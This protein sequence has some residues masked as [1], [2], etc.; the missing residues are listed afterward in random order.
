[1]YMG[2]NV[3]WGS[4]KG[5]KYCGLG[6]IGIANN[7]RGKGYGIYLMIK[8]IQYFQ[9]KG[10]RHMIID[11]TDLIDYYDKVEFKPW[12]KYFLLYKNL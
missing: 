1:L 6:P 11:W 9:Q 12:I 5:Q 3:N 8:I 7:C 2:S 4:Q 10:Y